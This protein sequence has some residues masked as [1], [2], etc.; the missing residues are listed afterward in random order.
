MPCTEQV[1]TNLLT[2]IGSTTISTPFGNAV[3]YI[4]DADTPFL[5]SIKDMDR[6]QVR[7]DSL[8]DVIEQPGSGKQLPIIRKFSHPFFIWGP[9]IK[10]IKGLDHSQIDSFLTE[11]EIRQ[12]HRR[13]GHPST[14]RLAKILERTG[15]NH[16]EQ[17]KEIL[18]KIEQFCEFCQR[19]SRSPGRFKFRLRDEGL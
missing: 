9:M 7:Y 12:L 3:F 11:P 14:E 16:D 6:L 5:L 8:A 18:R 15:H 4:L 19:H 1:P 17:T 2:Y 13:F 10:M